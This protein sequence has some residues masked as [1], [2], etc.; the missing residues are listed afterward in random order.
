MASATP[1][2]LAAAAG[3]PS[4]AP[5]AS[6]A[7]LAIVTPFEHRP[8]PKTLCLFDVD[9]TLSLARRSAKPEIVAAL[10]KLRRRCA[11][12]VVGG[13]DLKKIKEQLEVDGV[14]D[15]TQFVDYVFAENGLIGYKLGKELE[16]ASFI[17]W[18]GDDKYKKLVKF[19]LRYISELDLPIM[20]GTFVEFR[21]GMINVS[22]IGRNASNQER[23]DFEAYDAQH[24]IRKQFVDTLK[25][26]FADYGLTFSIGGQIS[27][28]I[29]PNGWDKTYALGR[30]E[31][32]G[33]QEIHFFGDKTYEGGNDYE[34]FSDSRTIG[35]T[36]DSPDTTLNLLEEIFRLSTHQ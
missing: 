17:N 10:A 16:A 19:V 9:G 26:E 5:V 4:S 24:K 13:S 20:R 14:P 3:A 6:T 25:K 22:P 28:D 12:G 15:L 29:F 11:V 8:L 18:I 23:D 35:H 33:W 27:F 36:V 2:A 7:G 34:I 1:S 31:H 30:I 21:N 32:E